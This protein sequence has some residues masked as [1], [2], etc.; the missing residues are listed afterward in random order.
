M[1][2]ICG[3]NDVSAV[4]RLALAD[5]IQAAT[6]HGD[7]TRGGLRCA[8]VELQSATEKRS[9]PQGMERASLVV[10]AEGRSDV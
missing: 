1:E 4:I 7:P 5:P 6:V 10:S 3:I 2:G 8:L 9:P